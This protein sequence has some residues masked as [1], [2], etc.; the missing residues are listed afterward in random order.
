MFAKNCIFACVHKEM[1]NAMFPGANYSFNESGLQ[2]QVFLAQVFGSHFS[3]ENS[4]IFSTKLLI[5]LKK[6]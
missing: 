3:F 4:C 2:N 1:D 6:T 5:L